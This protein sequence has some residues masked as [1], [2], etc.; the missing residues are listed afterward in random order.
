MTTED[1]KSELLVETKKEAKKAPEFKHVIWEEIKNKPFEIFGLPNQR[2]SDHCEVVAIGD[3]K[4]NLHLKVISSY[5]VP[6]RAS[7]SKS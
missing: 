6:N 7:L 1:K 3:G 4:D 2:V 5:W